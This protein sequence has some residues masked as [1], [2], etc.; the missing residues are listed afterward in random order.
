M[1]TNS[2][3]AITVDQ[4]NVWLGSLIGFSAGY[5]CS[6]FGGEGKPP[7]ASK[8]VVEQLPTME[9]SASQEGNASLSTES[10]AH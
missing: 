6:V 10:I 3:F 1:K 7:P 4:V 9:T 5:V 8:Q 2:V